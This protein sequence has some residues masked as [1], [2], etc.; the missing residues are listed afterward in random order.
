MYL[1]GVEFTME[2]R[3][4]GKAFRCPLRIDDVT[5][6]SVAKGGSAAVREFLR[7]T[8]HEQV[9]EPLLDLVLE[10]MTTREQDE[11][12]REAMFGAGPMTME[13]MTSAVACLAKE[14]RSDG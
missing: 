8:L 3:D 4:K 14:R 13:K 11:R 7:Q 2:Y 5:L 6:F 9:I 10:E 12:E 1:D